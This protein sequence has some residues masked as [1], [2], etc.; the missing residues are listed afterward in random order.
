MIGNI[1][2]A[3]NQN[4]RDE[5]S[6]ELAI[7]GIVPYN[8]L[9]KPFEHAT[10]EDKDTHK[11]LAQRRA[12]KDLYSVRKFIKEARRFDLNL[13]DR[14]DF[15]IAHLNPKV[16]SYGSAEELSF[17]ERSL[18]PVFISIEGGIEHTPYWLLAMF[19]EQCFFNSV[20]EILEH[21]KNI[22]NGTESI[23]HKFWRLLKKSW[24]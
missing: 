23:N 13:I 10:P 8:P 20:E 15:V 9:D 12:A 7:I 24:R 21:V 3:K 14:S 22:D 11:W 19:S 5:L 16:A 4:W 1:E 17:A 6:K 18:K 2:C